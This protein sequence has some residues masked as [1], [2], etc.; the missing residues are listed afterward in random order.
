VSVLETILYFVVPSA[1]LYLLISLLVVAPRFASSRPRYQ[2]GQ[3]WPHQP[4]WWTVSPED[5][6]LPVVDG[7]AVTGERGGAR[8]NW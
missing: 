2:V 5:A 6:K 7:P 3:P 4:L 8:G 1:G